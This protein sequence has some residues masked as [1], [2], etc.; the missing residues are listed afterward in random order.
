MRAGVI[1]VTG[2]VIKSMPVGERDRRVTLLTSEQGKLSFFARGAA[3][4]GSPF[5]GKT[6]PFSYGLF[7]LYQGRDSFTLESAEIRN[8]FPELN[9]DLET[10]CYASYFLELA[11]YFAREFAPEPRFLKLLYRSFLAL[12]KP[13]IPHALTR[14]IFELRMLVIDGTYD[15]EP[16]L[17]D[18]DRCRY[19]WQYICTAP[20]EKLYTFTVTEEILKELGDNVDAS[21]YRYVDREIHSLKVLKAML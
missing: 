3:K 16:P 18:S 10:T 1:E 15:P 2:M 8:Y 21:L 11:D 6:R 9:E 7:R 14:R 13:A 20:T 4:P 17:R 19:T 12:K 5:M